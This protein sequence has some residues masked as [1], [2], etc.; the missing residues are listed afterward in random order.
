MYVLS[1]SIRR[2]PRSTLLPYTTLFRSLN[3]PEIPQ[4]EFNDELKSIEDL[5]KKLI[6]DESGFMRIP[7]QEHIL[8]LREMTSSIVGRL[9]NSWQYRE[10]DVITDFEA[11]IDKWY[12]E[13]KVAEL[14]AEWAM[15]RLNNALEKSWW[16]AWRRG[17]KKFKTPI[18]ERE[19]IVRFRD[20]PVTFAGEDAK[21]SPQAQEVLRILDESYSEM[22]TVAHNAGIID[23][24]LDN[25]INRVYKD[26]PD[27]V[28]KTQ[29]GMSKKTLAATNTH[30]KAR[31]YITLQEAEG[32]GLH[33]ILDPVMLNGIY[34]LELG[35]SIANKNLIEALMGQIGRAH[36]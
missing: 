24:W 36:V 15:T 21:L 23:A 1:L 26:S 19:M 30:A 7:G 8:K 16:E 9:Q 31:K 27:K 14:Y 17:G 12:G 28:I 18:E 35:R 2:Q 34:V 10:H 11:A 6:Q 32:A 3:D 25:Y 33:P 22:W 5:V 4:Q 20:D 13:Q 29:Y